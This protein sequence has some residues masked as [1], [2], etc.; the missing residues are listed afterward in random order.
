MK[1]IFLEQVVK[2]RVT[3]G[4]FVGSGYHLAQ[5][6]CFGVCF[7]L[8]FSKI[9]FHLKAKI[10][11]PCKKTFCGYIAMQTYVKYPLGPSGPGLI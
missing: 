6:L 11:E 8:I 9:R 1:A 3:G 5:F 10:L 2:K 7:S 4:N